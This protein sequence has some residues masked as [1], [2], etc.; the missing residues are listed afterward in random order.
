M[1]HEDLIRKGRDH[2]GPLTDTTGTPPPDIKTRF[3]NLVAEIPR[4]FER[5]VQGRLPLLR[6]GWGLVRPQE[7]ASGGATAQ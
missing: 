4:A 6:I 5:P 2:R 3:P 1:S 7:P